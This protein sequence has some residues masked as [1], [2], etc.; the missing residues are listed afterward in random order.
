MALEPE[1]LRWLESLKPNSINSWQDLKR[2]FID[3]F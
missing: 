3:N 1:P 2:T